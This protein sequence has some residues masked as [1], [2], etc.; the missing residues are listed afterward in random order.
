MATWRMLI[1]VIFSHFEEAFVG[2]ASS[3]VV[4]GHCGAGGGGTESGVGILVLR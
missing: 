1:L 2:V 4:L 3:L